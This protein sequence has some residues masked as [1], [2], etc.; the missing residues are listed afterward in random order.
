MMFGYLSLPSPVAKEKRRSNP[1]LT[2]DLRILIKAAGFSLPYS[3]HI[4]FL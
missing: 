3:F 2:R 4:P 1:R